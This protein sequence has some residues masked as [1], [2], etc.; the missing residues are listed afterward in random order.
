MF[1]RLKYYLLLAG[2]TI[3]AILFG[4]NQFKERIKADEEAK[5]IAEGYRDMFNKNKSKE[6][7]NE[8]INSC[9]SSELNKFM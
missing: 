1:G 3:L 5:R 6:E 7:T 2:S 8:V 4:L 9:S